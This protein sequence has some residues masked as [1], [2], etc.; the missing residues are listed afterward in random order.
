MSYTAE[1]EKLPKLLKCFIQLFFFYPMA[2]LYR[3]AR[4]TETKKTATLVVGIVCIIPFV[5]FIFGVIDLICE[6]AHDKIDVL[7]D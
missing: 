2:V 3:V 5:G 6:I 4:Y 7:V 1:Y